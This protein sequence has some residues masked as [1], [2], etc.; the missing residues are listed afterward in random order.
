MSSTLM[1][2]LDVVDGLL[3]GTFLPFCD[4][5]VLA[6][7]TMEFLNYESLNAKQ[8]YDWR[9]ISNM[10]CI[11]DR[12]NLIGPAWYCGLPKRM[13]IHCDLSEDIWTHN[14]DIN[15]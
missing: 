15:I 8:S 12:P 6:E 4:C 9:N 13:E 2:C 5:C 11:T 1:N 14:K 10:Q 3:M 7:V